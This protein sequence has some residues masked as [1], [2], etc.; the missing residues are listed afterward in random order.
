MTPSSITLLL[1]PSRAIDSII[2]HFCRKRADASCMFDA[3]TFTQQA[4]RPLW[5]AI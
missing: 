4:R 1:I 2:G 3:F 5:F